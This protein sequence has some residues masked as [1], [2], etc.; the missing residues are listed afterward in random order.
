MKKGGVLVKNTRSVFQVLI[1][2]S[3]SIENNRSG[4]RKGLAW[5]TR[6]LF[7]ANFAESA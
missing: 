1:S 3:P 2:K 7:L 6:L 4:N 5:T